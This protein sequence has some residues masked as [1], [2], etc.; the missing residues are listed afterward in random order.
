MGDLDT[1]RFARESHELA[2]DV[3]INHSVFISMPLL[4]KYPCMFGWLVQVLLTV[5][6]CEGRWG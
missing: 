2:K 4:T 3:T 6:A 5:E 1:R